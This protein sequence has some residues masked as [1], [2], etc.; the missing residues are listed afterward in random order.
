MEIQVQ[1][2]RWSCLPTAFAMVL[3]IPVSQIFDY[4]GHNGEAIVWPQLEEPRCRRSFHIQEMI[5]FC[6]SKKY[7]VTGIDA[8]P[9]ATYMTKEAFND[10]GLLINQAMKTDCPDIRRMK[11][12]YDELAGR[13]LCNVTEEA[14]W[15]RMEKYL[16]NNHGVLTGRTLEGKP[17][18]VAWNGEMIYDPCGKMRG[19]EIFQISQFWIIKSMILPFAL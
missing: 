9:M 4:L 13:M 16:I 11:I 3:D 6:F 12:I 18:A 14:L 8:I 19:I 15:L 5:D 1:P 7:S 10:L 17:H 2:N